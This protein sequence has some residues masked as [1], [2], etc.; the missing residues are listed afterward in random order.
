[1]EGGTLD[2]IKKHWYLVLGIAGFLLWFTSQVVAASGTLSDLHESIN[3]NEEEIL[4][5]KEDVEKHE[6]SVGHPQLSDRLIRVETELVHINKSQS[7]SFQDIK[8]QLN[9][10]Q[11]DIKEISKNP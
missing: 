1:M 9:I 11:Q 10:L 8:L 7:E 2:A 5:L 6:T 3:H 4:D